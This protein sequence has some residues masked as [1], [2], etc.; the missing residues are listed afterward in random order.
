MKRSNDCIH[1]QRITSR[2]LQNKQW[3]TVIQV[4]EVKLITERTWIYCIQ[5]QG[6]ISK[7]LYRKEGNTALNVNQ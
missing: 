5:S 6:I 7:E 3:I 4:N 2:A 1:S